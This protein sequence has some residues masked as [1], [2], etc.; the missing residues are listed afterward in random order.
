MTERLTII[1]MLVAAR[2][3]LVRLHPAEADAARR[4]GAV[5]ID[6]RTDSQIAR[7]GAVPGSVQLS[8]N[9]LEWRLDPASTGF[10]PGIADLGDHVV[11][12]CDEG[13]SSSLAAARLQV[14]GFARA[15]DVIGGFQAWR[16]DGYPV[17]HPPA[18]APLP[19]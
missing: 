12:L 4:S 8:L 11:L 14:L 10:E 9:H 7:D 1:G 17:A 19:G 3:R 18:P 13:Y 5:L 15:T 6:V 16:R 2:E